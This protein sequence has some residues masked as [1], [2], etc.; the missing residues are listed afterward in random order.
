MI[1]NSWIEN[2]LY[3]KYERGFN[4]DN[5]K[6]EHVSTWNKVFIRFPFSN[7]ETVFSYSPRSARG[8]EESFLYFYILNFAFL[9][10]TY[11]P[12]LLFDFI[13]VSVFQRSRRKKKGIKFLYIIHFSLLSIA[14][15]LSPFSEFFPWKIRESGSYNIF[16]SIFG[17]IS[18]FFPSTKYIK[19][20]SLRE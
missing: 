17:A 14:V 3:Y 16:G 5:N 12:L 2:I 7:S 9:R 8:K 4:S 10:E 11:F 19:Y 15:Y 18:T 13:L 6:V 20:F 1:L